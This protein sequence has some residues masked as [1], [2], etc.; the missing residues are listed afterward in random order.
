METELF[1]R[2]P[3]AK[4]T[5]EEICEV[6]RQV[7]MSPARRLWIYR[8][9][10]AYLGIDPDTEC[11]GGPPG[12]PAQPCTNCFCAILEAAR[13]RLAVSGLS[14]EEIERLKDSPSTA[15]RW[16]AWRGVAAVA[17]YAVRIVAWFVLM[18]T[19]VL[20][21]G[22]ML[23]G[24]AMDKPVYLEAEEGF[25]DIEL[26][27]STMRMQ[28][29]GIKYRSGIITGGE[30]AASW[31]GPV[32]GFPPEGP[33]LRAAVRP[34]TTTDDPPREAGTGSSSGTPTAGTGQDGEKPVPPPTEPPP[35]D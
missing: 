23:T 12:N 27:G 29:K 16:S 30:A 32:S 11:K 17:A 15:R 3:P 9:C 28:G 14:L 21:C 1:E 22:T 18:I 10:R 31:D 2:T 19:L 20:L 25:L 5:R 33:L 6:L 4:A 7:P 13:P 24:C 26:G 35:K 34:P 8:A